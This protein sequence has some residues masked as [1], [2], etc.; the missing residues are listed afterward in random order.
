VASSAGLANAPSSGA[1]EATAAPPMA[2][3]RGVKV[4][5]GTAPA[6][7]ATNSNRVVENAMA[8]RALEGLVKRRVMTSPASGF[9]NYS[10]TQGMLVMRGRR[11]S[12]I[13]A[14]I[15]ETCNIPD[16]RCEGSGIRAHIAGAAK[17]GCAIR[18][19]AG[20]A[21]SVPAEHLPDGNLA[22]RIEMIVAIIQAF[23]V[24]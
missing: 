5:K 18:G 19:T 22:Q 13:P 23:D 21:G 4:P 17:P 24:T 7:D 14:C 16:E 11:C 10:Y 15:V 9:V 6:G 12:A 8:A 1:A 20:V 2:W 3:A